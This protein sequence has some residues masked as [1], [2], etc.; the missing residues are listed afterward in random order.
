[1]QET[2]KSSA[3]KASFPSSSHPC[4]GGADLLPVFPPQMLGLEFICAATISAKSSFYYV[5]G[6]LCGQNQKE[7][8]WWKLASW[9]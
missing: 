3:I 8:I 1:M 7:K 4:S 6:P 5:S 2:A 9:G